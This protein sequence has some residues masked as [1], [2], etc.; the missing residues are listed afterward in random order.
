MEINRTTDDAVRVV[1][2]LALAKPETTVTSVDLA[3]AQQL[4]APDLNRI[5]QQLTRAGLLR[6]APG[7]LGAVRLLHAPDKITVL[8]VVEAMEGPI[9]LNRCVLHPE[10]CPRHTTCPVHEL[11]ALARD[12]VARRLQSIRLSTLAA[13]YKKSSEK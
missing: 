4:S 5:L 12:D 2:Q 10:E 13:R 7:S 11:W 9:A 1:L 3:R 8:D 6:A